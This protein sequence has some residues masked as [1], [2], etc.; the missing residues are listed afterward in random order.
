MSV[1][2]ILTVKN[3]TKMYINLP[4]TIKFRALQVTVKGK[5]HKFKKQN[6]G[7][8]LEAV[9]KRE[10][11]FILQNNNYPTYPSSLIYCVH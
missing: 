6:T 10:L 9:V 5:Q 2:D 11:L 7:Y 8:C 3:N 4:H 1:T